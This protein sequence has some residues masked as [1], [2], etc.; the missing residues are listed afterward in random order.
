M[1]CVSLFVFFLL[2]RLL[3]LHSAEEVNRTLPN[4]SSFQCGKLGII[5]FPFT[6][7]S[8]PLC[9]LLPVKCDEMPPTIQLG[10]SR[11]PY[12]VIN[13]SY[14]NT[15]LIT[16]IKDLLLSDAL[17]TQKCESVT[18]FTLPNSPFIS[19]KLTTPSQT[20]FKCNR[21]LGIASPRNFTRRN[22]GDYSLYYSHLNDD[23]QSFPAQC[24]IIQLPRKKH[25]DK[26]TLFS[27]LSAEFDL[28]VNV[29]E[30]CSSCY[31][32]G[33]HCELEQNGKFQCDIAKKVTWSQR[34]L[35]ATVIAT[36]SVGIG[37]LMVIIC[38]F[39]GQGGY[40]NVYKGKLQ[41]GCFVAVKVLKES[42]GNGDE[43]VNE[44][45]SI[46]RT[47]HVNIVTLKGFCIEGSKRALIYEFMS[48][49]SLEKFIY[50]GNPS[51]SNH[52]L[53]WETLYKISIGIARGLEYLHRGCNAQILHFDIKPHNIL[54]DENF[55]PKISDFGL[56]KICP[57]EKSF[58]SMVS[59]RGTIGYMAPEVFCRNFGGISHKSDVYSYGM[60]VL[61]MVG[62]RKNFDASVDFT[63]E[64]YF[65]HW[66]YKRLEL[67]EEL[68]LLGLLEKVDQEN[69]RKMI[70]V[71][72]WCI[73]SDP[74]IRPSM[75]KVVNMLE[76]S[77]E[78]F[79]IPPKPFLCSPP[80]SPVDSST[81]MV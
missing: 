35:K 54:L 27:L 64:I 46:S 55:C 76:G 52:Q 4:C 72:L 73:Q 20:L 60:M 24:S 56:A 2:S 68:G 5:G 71:S 81:I 21:T 17:I 40:S 66:I 15:T 33:G 9:G 39:W 31:G 44:V 49:G 47:S 77:L 75:S 67:G 50:K 7:S 51:N 12:E 74:S 42:K 59:A 61:E 34:R 62:G 63:S 37:V 43:F 8:H 19:F 41:D 22:C 25:S 3:L 14:T 78:P 28:E 70:M 13:I 11:G 10:W 23:S 38:C 18:N 58:I 30:A 79:K 29:S 53:G 80:S 57:R 48:N 16:R 36:S 1:A 32:G 26:D 6:D 45:A 69:A 65:P